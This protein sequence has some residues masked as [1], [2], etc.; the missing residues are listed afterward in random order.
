MSG[1]KRKQKYLAACA[2]LILLLFQSA[3]PGKASEGN[4][5]YFVPM[6]FSDTT[7]DFSSLDCYT[8]RGTGNCSKCHG[9]REYRNPNPNGISYIPCGQCY[10]SGNCL[11]CGG[12]GK[13]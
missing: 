8:C 4:G 13:R 6:A 7:P 1:D 5:Y 10:M 12:S 2:A 3:A 9:Y 11:S